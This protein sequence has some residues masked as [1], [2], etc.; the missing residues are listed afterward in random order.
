MIT[1]KEF[2]DNGSEETLYISTA[3]GFA[4]VS[5]IKWPETN[6]WAYC[7]KLN[8]GFGQSFMVCYSTD[9]YTQADIDSLPT[10][11]QEMMR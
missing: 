11:K 3:W 1:V 5:Y 7:P 10:Y 4:E 8:G 6:P 9:L 2:I